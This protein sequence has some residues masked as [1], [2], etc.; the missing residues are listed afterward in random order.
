MKTKMKMMGWEAGGGRELAN[1]DDVY[2]IIYALPIILFGGISH[3]ECQRM[4]P[5]LLDKNL[6]SPGRIR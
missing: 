4:H 2:V 1:V 3:I 5:A 6:I